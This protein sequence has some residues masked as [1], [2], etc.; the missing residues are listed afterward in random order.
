MGGRC[1]G[2]GIRRSGDR[3][4]KGAGTRKSVVVG[5]KGVGAQSASGRNFQVVGFHERKKIA[6]IAYDFFSFVSLPLCLSSQGIYP[7]GAHMAVLTQILPTESLKSWE[8]P[9]EP[10]IPYDIEL[11]SSME[12]ICP[13][14]FKILPREREGPQGNQ[15]VPNSNSAFSS[16]WVRMKSP[17]SLMISNPSLFFNSNPIG[18][19]M[20]WIWSL[21]L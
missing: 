20:L 12:I 3:E 6:E 10:K 18:L 15:W 17:F 16:G 13:Q 14:G 9:G 21:G 2:M 11:Y 4:G 1:T 5:K 8:I 7:C 19:T